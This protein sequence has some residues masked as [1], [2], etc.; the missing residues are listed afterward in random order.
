LESV[1]AAWLMGILRAS[2]H[3]VRTGPLLGY[4]SEALDLLSAGRGPD[5][6]RLLLW[7]NRTDVKSL[8]A[9][10]QLAKEAG[11]SPSDLSLI[12]SM[13]DS[14]KDRLLLREFA[15]SESM[16]STVDRRLAGLG[17]PVGEPWAIV[18]LL[19]ALFAYDRGRPRGHHGQGLR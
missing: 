10:I 9:R 1:R 16:L 4:L 15:G 5:A 7:M 17:F 13:M 2:F 12:E 19:I 8:A 3:G 11:A 14:A 18:F 6:V